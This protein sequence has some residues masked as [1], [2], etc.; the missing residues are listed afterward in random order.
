M[1]LE[2][3]SVRELTTTEQLQINGGGKLADFFAAVWDGI[4][5]VAEWIWENL[6]IKLEIEIGKFGNIVVS[7]PD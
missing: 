3:F 4:V 2:K 7:K 6:D 5:T 1:E